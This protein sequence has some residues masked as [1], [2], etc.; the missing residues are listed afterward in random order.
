[1]FQ[2]YF[3]YV[4]V[5]AKNACSK[6]GQHGSEVQVEQLGANQG[7]FFWFGEHLGTG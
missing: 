1:M 5:R 3:R 2:G 4:I 7:D 6:S